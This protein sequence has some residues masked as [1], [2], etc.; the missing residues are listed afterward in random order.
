MLPFLLQA[1]NMDSR[2]K[3]IIADVSNKCLENDISLFLSN[4]EQVIPDNSDIGSS[5][6][7]DIMYRRI[8]A[9]A[10]GKPQSV[11]LATLL[12]EDSHL[13]Q[14]LERSPVWEAQALPCG[15]DA[16]GILFSWVEEQAAQVGTESQ[17]DAETL[18]DCAIRILQLEI[19]CERRT[20]E[21][22][23][24][25]GIC[26]LLNPDIYT[27]K[28]NAYGYFYLYMLETGRF[29]D[30]GFEPYTVREVWSQAPS[31][32]DCDYSKIPPDL[33][34]AFRTHLRK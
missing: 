18:K 14:Y 13:D 24:K 25:Y 7:F 15:R 2:I 17:W 28:A 19:D 23:H 16:G 5:G 22:I 29:Y 4:Q 12:H 3:Q 11:W 21:K 9:V 1:N 31:T 20:L 8:L 26:D 34:L 27:Q 32:F 10:C 30:N 6:Y 33:H